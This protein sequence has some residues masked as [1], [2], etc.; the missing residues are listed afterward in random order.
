MVVR[1]LP[2]ELYRDGSASRVALAG[3]PSRRID[4]G[5]APAGDP[6]FAVLQRAARWTYLEGT[7]IEV[8]HTLLT[9]ELA[10]EWKPERPFGDGL[11]ERLEPALDLASLVYKAHLRSG[12][13]D[14]LKALA[15]LRKTL[16]L[17]GP[18]PL[19]RAAWA[20]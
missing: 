6:A 13:K 14:T 15:D 5:E 9:A 1:S 7:D 17:D 3:R 16:V 11:A 19:C 10:R 20:K 12:S 2:T 18:P 8:R 4:L